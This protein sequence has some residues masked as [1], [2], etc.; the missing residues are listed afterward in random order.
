MDIATQKLNQKNKEIAMAKKKFKKQTSLD[1]E[2]VKITPLMQSYMDKQEHNNSTIN[3]KTEDFS[4]KFDTIVAIFFSDWHIGTADFDMAGA[5]EALNY[6]LKT[7]NAL[8]FVVGDTLNTAIL[9][10]VS[11]MF[12]DIA[13]PQEQWQL[14]VSLFQEVAKQGKLTVFHD[15]N[16]EVRID[17]QTGMSAISQASSALG[18][19]EAHAPYY[20]IRNVLL[21]NPQCKNG[22]FEIPFVTH[23]GD[24]IGNLED[25][26]KLHDQNSNSFINAVG[27]KHTFRLRIRSH[28]FFN[29]KTAQLT[30]KDCLDIMLPS[31]GGGFY[32]DRKM[33][34]SNFRSPYTAIELTSI[35]N[36]RYEQ[37]KGSP[38][39]ELE[40][41]PV[42][43][44]I[45]IMKVADTVEKNDHIKTAKK[46]I[47][48]YEKGL[49]TEFLT[50][51][52]DLLSWMEGQGQEIQDKI[53]S[54]LK[55]RIAEKY[56]PKTPMLEKVKAASKPV[57]DAGNSK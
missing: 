46:A 38:V 6:V 16:H 25:M 14:A 1:K 44:S 22:A 13:Y 34:R 45:P 49:R 12:E 43:R 29:E 15:G 33:Y 47:K 55:A 30:R 36:P 31:A 28:Q 21:K 41:I 5:I 2:S 48:N 3:V 24:G 35:K 27:D 20:A 52:E 53:K 54:E 40:F 4:D 18:I 7:P 11:N 32:G 50:K 42:Y 51:V 39:E 57:K 56:Q 8:L 19:P 37:F 9:G 23:H 17:K 10:S 26:K